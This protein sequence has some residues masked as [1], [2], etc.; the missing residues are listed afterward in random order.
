MDIQLENLSFRYDSFGGGDKQV[1]DGVDLTIRSG[2]FLAL[3]G[4]SGSGKTTLMQHLTG[5]LKPT[6]GRVRIDGIDLWS[7]KANRQ[8]VRTKIGLVFQFPESQFFEETVFSDVGFGPRNLG[9]SDSEVAARVE[10][11]IDRVGLEFVR[12][13]DRTPFRL[14][15]GEKRRIAIAGILAMQPEALVLDEPTAGLD[16]AGIQAVIR[17][18]EDFHAEGKTVLLISHDMNLINRLVNRIVLLLDGRILFDGDKKSL[19]QQSELLSRAGLPLPR[20]VRLTSMLYEKGWIASPELDSI[21]EITNA[22]SVGM[23]KLF[24][25]KPVAEK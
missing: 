8:A 9:L 16:S 19:F 25:N 18:L 17:I 20:I 24:R 4:P 11:A 12:Y 13:R 21:E 7:Q 1:L 10:D 2:E 14:S 22:I 3:V 5:L 6:R 15:E 23:G